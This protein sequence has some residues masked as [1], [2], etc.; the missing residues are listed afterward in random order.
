MYRKAADRGQA[1]AQ[2]NMAV[3]YH[4]AE[5]VPRDHRLAYFWA[6]LAAAQDFPDAKQASF[7]F[8]LPLTA[9]VRAKVREEVKGWKPSKQ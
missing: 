6:L 1:N 7:E 5:G 9:E 4:E 8:G 2:F 3:A